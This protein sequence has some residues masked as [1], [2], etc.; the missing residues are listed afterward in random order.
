MKSVHP[1]LLRRVFLVFLVLPCSLLFAQA[2]VKLTLDAGALV[3]AGLEEADWSSFASG[4]LDFQSSASAGVRG[5]LT[6]TAMLLS[7]N[8]AALARFDITRLFIRA[9]LPLFDGF[10]PRLSVGKN[11]IAWGKGAFFNAGNLFF[12]KAGAQGLL[13][14]VTA[15]ARNETEWLALLYIPFGALSFAE[16][17]ASIPLPAFSV[18]ATPQGE[19]ML[20]TPVEAGSGASYGARLSGNF[21]AFAAELAW[22][23]SGADDKQEF[24]CSV[25][26]ALGD[27]E[28]YGSYALALPYDRARITG[29]LLAVNFAPMLDST[30]FRLEALVQPEA[31]WEQ[32]ELTDE[33]RLDGYPYG[34][35]IFADVSVGLGTA[36]LTAR[37]LYSPIDSSAL[38]SLTLLWKPYQGLWYYFGGSI[39]AGSEGALYESWKTGSW[40]ATGGLRFVF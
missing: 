29:G 40:S 24:S 17:A 11:N 19:L 36:V 28:L 12:G 39:N 27:T 14:G 30:S 26:G 18:V 5:R 2:A 6:M 8:G 23:Y 35:H 38:F 15:L 25:S 22:H 21:D 7:V 37:S 13:G 10:V 20:P 3:H 9:N 34:V 1:R 32:K 31:S 16:A 4:E 33:E